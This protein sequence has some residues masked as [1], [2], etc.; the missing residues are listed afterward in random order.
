MHH[1]D[2]QVWQKAKQLAVNVYADCRKGD[3]ARDYGFRD[4]MQRASV[5][6]ASNIAEGYARESAKDRCHLLV[7]AKGSCAELQTQIEI[8][9]EIGLLDQAGFARLDTQCDEVARMLTGLLKTLRSSP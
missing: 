1:R 5:S 2:L 9:R 6:I 3:L 4:Q 8:A 7:V